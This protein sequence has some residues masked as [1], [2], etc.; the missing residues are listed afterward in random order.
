MTEGMEDTG[1]YTFPVS[2]CVSANLD[3]HSYG[4]ITGGQALCDIYRLVWF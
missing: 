4:L 1:H 2:L 3:Y